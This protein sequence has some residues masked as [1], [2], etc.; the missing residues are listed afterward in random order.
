MADW[1]RTPMSP[2]RRCPDC[3]VPL[4]E[5]HYD[6]THRGNKI[7]LDDPDSGGILSKLGIGNS[8]YAF[9]YV[10]SECGLVRFYAE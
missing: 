2:S 6:V 10:C 8:T 4:E 7:Q 3:D 9:A 5:V 1:N